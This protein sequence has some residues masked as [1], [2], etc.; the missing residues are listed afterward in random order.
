MD[1]L[2]TLL[3][4][5]YGQ[6]ISYV[7]DARDG[8]PLTTE[9]FSPGTTSRPI[10]SSEPRTWNE[11]EFQAWLIELPAPY[12]TG[13]GYLMKIVWI[14]MLTRDTAAK[15]IWGLHKS[16]LSIHPEDLSRV[17]EVFNVQ[18]AF[19]YSFT[20]HAGYTVLEE[21]IGS[22]ERST[23]FC[24]FRRNTFIVAWAKDARSKITKALVVAGESGPH[25]RSR[26]HEVIS[27]QRDLARHS[28][29]LALV[30]AIWEG[31]HV[32]DCLTASDTKI[33]RIENRTG[34]HPWTTD[35]A[36]E[37]G[38][39]S[40]LSRKTSGA[41]TSL[42]ELVMNIQFM[43]G[44]LRWIE[45]MD[46]SAL[47]EDGRVRSCIAMIKARLD[48]QEILL[49]FLQERAKNQMTVLFTLIAS[50]DARNGI[51]LARDSRT[52]AVASKIDS[53]S[54][55]TLAAVSVVFLPGTFVASFFS[56]PLFDLQ[57]H[58]NGVSRILWI[59]W[60]IT[61]PLTAITISVWYFWIR[62]KREL[63]NYATLS[64][65]ETHAFRKTQ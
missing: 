34:Y 58:P 14:P 55:K 50:E 31:T 49:S 36:I 44:L 47:E 54:M 38:S 64:R 61:I 57:N 62:R 63:I 24:I 39:Y 52:L 43:R 19:E 6:N 7:I 17:L 11:S 8:F 53:S 12:L 15:R 30:V 5:Y 51:E 25:R 59:Y 18:L 40:E 27:H 29:F 21:G 35:D 32:E 2:C 20:N 60:I 10:L 16:Q 46:N 9:L 4:K 48:Q 33:T 41:S 56:M 13:S 23:S 42:A 1:G 65:T 37:E 26:L 22:A 3:T 28:L 45:G